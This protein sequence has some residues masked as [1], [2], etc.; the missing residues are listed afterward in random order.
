MSSPLLLFLPYYS[1]NPFYTFHPDPFL[2]SSPLHSSPTLS[3]PLPSSSCSYSSSSFHPIV[4]LPPPV[5]STIFPSLLLLP[6]YSSLLPLP[7]TRSSLLFYHP[8]YSLPSSSFPSIP[9]SI[10]SSLPLYHI[11]SSSTSF[12]PHPHP[13]PSRVHP[14]SADPEL[15]SVEGESG[16]IIRGHRGGGVVI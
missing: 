6:F 12:P 14:R 4:T 7:S 8:P 5:P 11:P 13:L 3:I 2:L 1:F 16:P 9:P 15:D 10:L